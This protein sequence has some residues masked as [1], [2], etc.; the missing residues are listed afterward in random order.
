MAVNETLQ[1][2]DAD[3]PA[4]NTPAGTDN[5][6]TDLD[7]H[8]RDIKKNAKFA[9]DL[10]VGS[11]NTAAVTMALTDYNSLMLVD[12]SAGA[13]TLSVLTASAGITGFR[14]GV[15]NVS[16]ANNVV[17]EGGGSD[18]IDGATAITLSATNQAVMLTCNGS[19]WYRT[20]AYDL[21]IPASASV[22]VFTSSGTWTKPANL[23]YAII[24]VQGG[25][26]GGGGT[27]N[28][29]NDE[30]GAGSGGGAGGYA[31]KLLLASAL[32][33][34]ET[35]TVG[36]AAS[37]GSSSD[38]TDGN[39]STFAVAS[40]TNIVG[41]GGTGGK[42]RASGVGT[43]AVLQGVAGGSA[44]GGDVTITGSG[45]GPAVCMGNSAF[46]TSSGQSLAW[47]SSGGSGFF[48]G[49][50]G[51]SA[52]TENDARNGGDGTSGGGGGGAV[53]G[54][55]GGAATGGGGGAGIGVVTQD[56]SE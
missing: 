45:S 26:G 21:P 13:R 22:A 10:R 12:P 30:A 41:N 6:G 19:T 29:A 44:T 16:G 14:V 50:G 48:G 15:K 46:G 56:L 31:R 36:A 54:D 7:A 35:V 23:L 11:T 52:S 1:S 42:S 5:V 28:P 27:A 8:L 53:S 18:T 2:Y 3:T 43:V 25:G 40:G 9:G 39:A 34:T 37:G 55:P 20:S 24:E 33:S 38:G 4:N 51:S 32:G 17:L 47:A 49:G